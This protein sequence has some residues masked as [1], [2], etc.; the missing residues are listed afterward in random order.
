MVDRAVLRRT[1][2]GRSQPSRPHRGDVIRSPGGRP[3]NDPRRNPRRGADWSPVERARDLPASLAR[4]SRPRSRRYAVD[5]PRS[6]GQGRSRSSPATAPPLPRRIRRE[7]FGPVELEAGREARPVDSYP[8][9]T[10]LRREW[11]F[12]PARARGRSVR[13][14]GSRRLCPVHGQGPLQGGAAR[15]RDPGGAQRDAAP[16]RRDREPVRLPRLRQACESRLV[17]RDLEGAHARQA[18]RSI[19]RDSRRQGP[20]R[21]GRGRREVECWS[22]QPRSDRVVVG[23][24]VAHPMYDSAKY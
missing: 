8:V 18:R 5:P 12:R 1:R 15:P 6:T 24:I 22:S 10:P 17:G 13:G 23:E 11:T 21:G 16:R 7:T 3:A 2:P 4:C 20:Q 19:S 14:R 9:S